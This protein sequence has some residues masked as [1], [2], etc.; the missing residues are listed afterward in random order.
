MVCLSPINF[1]RELCD[2]VRPSARSSTILVC[3][4]LSFL[5]HSRHH[6]R[7]LLVRDKHIHHVH[8]IL[9]EIPIVSPSPAAC[10]PAKQVRGEEQL[11]VP[12]EAL[13]VF[14]VGD[15]AGRGGGGGVEI[16]VEVGVWGGG[17]V[18]RMMVVVVV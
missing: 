14:C 7:G 3:L 12:R 16:V 6:R 5:Q 17:M 4:L 2:V 15:Q 10:I 8:I 9:P 1:G 18:V 13:A 11:V